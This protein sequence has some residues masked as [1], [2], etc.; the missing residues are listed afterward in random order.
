M[1]K[2]YIVLAHGSRAMEA[3]ESLKEIA[4]M[5]AQKLNSETVR[6][7]Y[8]SHGKP[9]LEDAAA[10][11]VELGCS[12]VVVA[13]F[14]LSKGIHLKEDIPG[15]LEKLE[16]KFTTAKFLFTEHLGVDPRLADIL[17]D[18]IGAVE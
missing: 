9:S 12:S 8:M 15:I 2:G 18:R 11:L 4:D 3:N 6:A 13:P 5:V 7:A 10:E 17:V 14:F 1:K 16:A